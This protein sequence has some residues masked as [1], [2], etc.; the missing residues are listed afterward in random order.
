MYVLPVNA[1][2]TSAP[3]PIELVVNEG[4]AKFATAS[5]PAPDSVKDVIA[6]VPST[7][8]IVISKSLVGLAPPKTFPGILITPP[9]VYPASVDP[10]FLVTGL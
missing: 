7:P 10:A 3:V 4:P 5:A 6:P 9:T 8:E 1:T 2:L